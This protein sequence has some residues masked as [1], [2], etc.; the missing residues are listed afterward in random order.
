MGRPLRIE[1]E[2]ACYHVTSRGNEQKDIFKSK[3]DREKFLGY[4]ESAVFR[5]GAIVHAWCLMTNH[6]H[7][8]LETPRGNLS[9]IMRHI[10]GAYTNYFNAKRKRA[11]HLFQGRYKAILI[12]A[13]AYLVELSRYIHLNPVRAG[14]V[15]KPEDYPWSSYG[16]YVDLQP[17]V[18][19]HQTEFILEHFAGRSDRYRQFVEDLLDKA[20]ES[21][22]TQTVAATVLGSETFVRHFT[23]THVAQKPAGRDVPAVRHLAK[24]LQLEKILNTVRETMTDEETARKA[25]IYLAHRYS[26]ARLKELG[27]YFG[28]SESGVSQLSRRFEVWMDKN[29]MVKKEV[30]GIIGKLCLSRV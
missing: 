15:V 29:E 20:Y 22:L 8:L 13:D 12:E 26:G 18:K 27:V 19:W 9:Q 11:G 2:G 6:Y 1:F 14:I 3:R 7:L 17:P 10:N 25:S 30:E 23:E 5:Y 21:P 16:A 24:P 28:L 4:L